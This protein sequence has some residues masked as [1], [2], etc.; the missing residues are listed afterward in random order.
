MPSSGLAS[1]AVGDR[2]SVARRGREDVSSEEALGLARSAYTLERA[3][4]QASHT[5]V[6]E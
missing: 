4:R 6:S 5:I 1:R 3:T 2:A